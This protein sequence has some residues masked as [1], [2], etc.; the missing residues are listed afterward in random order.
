MAIFFP[1]GYSAMSMS[2]MQLRDLCLG[3]SGPMKEFI[4][5][6]G[7]DT[8]VVRGNS[9]TSVAYAMHAL[10]PDMFQFV[11]ARKR[12]E[13][14]NS[15]GQLIEPLCGPRNKVAVRRYVVLDDFVDSGDTVKGITDDMEDYDVPRDCMAGLILYRGHGGDWYECD[16]TYAFGFFKCLMR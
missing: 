11:V 9:G 8:I 6:L 7:A 3:L 4:Q 16:R 10:I 1:S 12:A 13:H 2:G 15:H 5:R 14:S